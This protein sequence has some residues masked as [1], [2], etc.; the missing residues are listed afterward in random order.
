MT[1]PV[2]SPIAAVLV[3]VGGSPAPVLFTLLKRR[4][5]HV[6][7]F[8]SADSRQV[9][10]DIH[11]Q[12]DWRPDR[13]FIEVERF[14][15]LGPCY[16]ELRAAIP[17]LLRKWKVPAAEVLVDYTGGTKTMSAAL[18]LA[19]IE[20]FDQFSY[21]GGAQR[22]QGGLGVTVDGREKVFYQANP[23]SDLAVREI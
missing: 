8:C 12:L 11:A 22:E 9:A 1:T 16:K 19:A 17:A 18:V 3:S 14:E 13:D 10:D 23:W 6:W 21:V 20:T 5:A 7:Y 2:S 4:P 15:E